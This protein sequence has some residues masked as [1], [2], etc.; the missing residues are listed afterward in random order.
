MVL[1]FIFRAESATCEEMDPPGGLTSFRQKGG[2]G[3]LPVIPSLCHPDQGRGV[4]SQARSARSTTGNL[5]SA[6]ARDGLGH[7]RNDPEGIKRTALDSLRG[8][9]CHANASVEG[10]LPVGDGRNNN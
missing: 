2:F 6:V 5:D 10:Q 4:P 3:L 8:V 1:T 9:Q 7:Q